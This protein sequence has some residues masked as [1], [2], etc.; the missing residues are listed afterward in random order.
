MRRLPEFPC[1]GSLR[2]VE[3]LYVHVPFCARKCDYCALYSVPEFDV[4][5]S[6]AYPAA[7]FE[8]LGRIHA[9]TGSPLRP[10][11]LY[12]GG[13]SPDCNPDLLETLVEGLRGRLDLSRLEEWT[14]ELRPIHRGSSFV[15]RLAKCGVNRASMGIQTL[16]CAVL[17]EVHRLPVPAD[18]P[19]TIEDLRAGG[20]RNIGVDFIA[21]LPGTSP[22]QTLEDIRRILPSRPAH[23]SVYTLIVEPGTP[24]ARRIAAGE[25]SVPDDDAQMD[26]LER[27][28][29]ELR[30]HGYARYEISNYA[31]RG[32]RCLY[33][34]SVWRGEDYLGLGP[35]AASRIGYERWTNLPDVEAY[36]EAAQNGAPF[37]RE[38]TTQS[39]ADDAEERFLFGLRLAEGV[40]PDGFA[41]RRPDAA[42]LAPHWKATLATA[43]RQGLARRRNTRWRLTE[44]GFEVADSVLA[45]LCRE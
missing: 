35:S 18:I 44:R 40:D 10:R 11:T 3:H 5:D 39:P 2:A 14:V 28:A 42:P 30:N 31:K 1:I 27:A 32:R 43:A 34:L 4:A 6:Q 17:R 25:L 22:E 38:R 12:I 16:N 41:A 15:R 26:A 36:L 24:L 9:N 19:R 45:S 21:G 20:I 13:G 37:S 33:N 29:R 8:E 7:V 23:V